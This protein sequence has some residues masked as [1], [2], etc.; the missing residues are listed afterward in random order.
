[1]PV[2]RRTHACKQMHVKRPSDA[3]G[4][5]CLAVRAV[6]L[7]RS[8]AVLASTLPP[9]TVLTHTVRMQGSE[10]YTY[11]LLFA[12]ARYAFMALEAHGSAAVMH[13]YSG[14]L[15]CLLRLRQA[16][17]LYYYPSLIAFF[18]SSDS[19]TPLPYSSVIGRPLFLGFF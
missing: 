9:M 15:E 4:R 17:T 6:S 7:R 12:S 16:S 11:D 5:V 18:Y 19:D 1:M 10:R 14:V 8:S 13:H 3:G 2:R